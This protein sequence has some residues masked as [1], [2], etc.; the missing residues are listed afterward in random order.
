MKEQQRIE[1]LGIQAVLVA[2]RNADWEKA[3]QAYNDPKQEEQTSETY[4]ERLGQLKADDAFKTM[5]R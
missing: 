3:K 5:T 2:S 4:M 1:K